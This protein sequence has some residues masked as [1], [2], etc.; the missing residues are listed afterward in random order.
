MYVI[1]GQPRKRDVV[2]L[3]QLVDFHANLPKVFDEDSQQQH[4]S[5]ELQ[6]AVPTH[7]L[8]FECLPNVLRV[9]VDFIFGDTVDLLF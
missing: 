7:V 2:A 9:L 5:F 6:V 1:P 4:V 3:V 8:Q